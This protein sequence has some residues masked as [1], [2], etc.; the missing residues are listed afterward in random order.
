MKSQIFGGR[1]GPPEGVVVPNDAKLGLVVGVALVL[2]VA[3]IF[4]RKDTHAQA[5]AD[6]SMQSAPASTKPPTPTPRP[7]VAR[8][9]RRPHLVPE[10]DTPVRK[11]VVREGETLFSLAQRYY[12]DGEQFQLIYR[13]NQHEAEATDPLPAGTVLLIPPV[14]D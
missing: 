4:F 1:R 10:T 7:T 12:G 13:A 9:N 6:T 3:V 14:K 8:A 11:H 5:L 2:T